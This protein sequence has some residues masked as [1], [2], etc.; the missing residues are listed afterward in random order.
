MVISMNRKKLRMILVLSVL[1]ICCIVFQ[2]YEKGYINGKDTS[3]VVFKENEKITEKNKENSVQKSSDNE[4]QTKNDG[5]SVKTQKSAKV[6]KTTHKHK[7]KKKHRKSI[8]NKKAKKTISY[9]SPVVS[10]RD[11]RVLIMDTGFSSLYHDKVIISCKQGF[12]VKTGSTQKSYR[13]GKK[14][15]F[16]ASDKKWRNKKITICPA[17]GS[18]LMIKSIK[19]QN[20]TPSYR[21][22]LEVKWSKKGFLITNELP[23]EQYLY[24]V[25]PSEISTKNNIEA[26]KAQAVCARSYAYKQISDGR[27]KKYHADM[28]D[29]VSFQVYNNVPEDSR[30]IKAVDATNGKVMTSGGDIIV[31][32]YFSTSWGYTADGQDVWNTAAAV[33]Y[34][35]ERFQITKKAKKNSGSAAA[36]SSL[37]DDATFRN[38]INSDSYKTYDSG[39]EWYRW[40][41]NFQ[42]K[43]LESRMDSILYSCYM[44]DKSH[45]LTRLKNGTYRSKSLKRIG[46]LKNIRIA[47]REKSGLVTQIIISGSKSTVKVYTQYN[48]R[49]IFAPVSEKIH[50][51]GAA[52]VNTYT[53]L[54]SAAFYIDTVKSGKKLIFKVTGGGFGHGTGMSQEGAAAMAKSGESYKSILKHYFQ[55]AVI[56]KVA[57]T[58]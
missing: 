40:S 12:T 44:A 56:Q 32:Y 3:S 51:K 20:I 2:A 26:L 58:S 54:P 43:K 6:Q 8:K 41:V 47:K 55:G 57:F 14:V 1:C 34:L 28:D 15:G 39:K 24:A 21:G 38:F 33:P 17:S 18:K 36:V 53:L 4:I 23:V 50:R 35:K 10:P 29:S 48:I 52:T 16:K 42:A 13:G 31:A 27:Y 9:K 7:A 46:T 37:S 22:I 25:V 19:R 5:D 49:K 30:S 45:V 11:V